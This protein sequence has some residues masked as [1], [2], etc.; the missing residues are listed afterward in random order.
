MLSYMHSGPPWPF[1]LASLGS[2][3]Y[4][5]GQG[6]LGAAGDLLLLA[7]PG[8]SPTLG[9]VCRGQRA[10]AHS[11]CVI[12]S[13]IWV[14]SASLQATWLQLLLQA[15]ETAGMHSAG[16][17]Y[18]VFGIGCGLPARLMTIGVLAV[19]EQQHQLDTKKSRYLAVY[20]EKLRIL[21]PAAASPTGDLATCHS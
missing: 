7:P 10:R 17:S 1:K 9:A 14:V 6:R 16:G 12:F 21:I 19:D 11:E 5:W 13:H 20:R 8:G 4:S 18:I 15:H 2:Y 3:A